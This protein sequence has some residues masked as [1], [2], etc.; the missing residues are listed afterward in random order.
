MDVFIYIYIYIIMNNL[1]L[2]HIY[3]DGCIK[4]IIIYC[5]GGLLLNYMFGNI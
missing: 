5:D 4:Y 2:I 3:C 1:I